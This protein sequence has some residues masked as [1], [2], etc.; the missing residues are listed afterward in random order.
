[1]EDLIFTTRAV[2]EAFATGRS[3]AAK[4]AAEFGISR[5]AIHQWAKDQPIPGK[6]LL[7]LYLKRPDIIAKIKAKQG[8]NHQSMESQHGT[9]QPAP[10]ENRTLQ[11]EHLTENGHAA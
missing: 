8:A 1:M 4:A 6:R 10:S 2:L 7:H 11:H 3:G 5:S 9:E